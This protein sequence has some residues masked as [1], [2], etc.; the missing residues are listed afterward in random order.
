MR[1]LMAILFLT[2]ASLGTAANAHALCT[3]TPGSSSGHKFD[4]EHDHA[5]QDLGSSASTH[6]HKN[7]KKSQ[8]KTDFDGSANMITVCHGN[9]GCPG[10]VLAAGAS[11]RSTNGI[12]I[13]FRH[14]AI[15]GNSTDP[16]SSLRPPKFS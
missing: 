2:T 5:N 13:A 12:A 4:H 1:T 8:V 16:D 14:S 3:E 7:I 6:S 10:C 15:E 9:A 11:I